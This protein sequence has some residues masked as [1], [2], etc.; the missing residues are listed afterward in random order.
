M[1][2]M[3]AVKRVIGDRV[4]YITWAV[5]CMFRQLFRMAALASTISHLHRDFVRLCMDWA[6]WTHAPVK[7]WPASA[8]LSLASAVAISTRLVRT[9]WHRILIAVYCVGLFLLWSWIS[10]NYR[11][12]PFP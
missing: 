10:I 5:A 6:N 9:P 12:N 4:R 11:L 3:F 2:E 8:W 7:D 1:D